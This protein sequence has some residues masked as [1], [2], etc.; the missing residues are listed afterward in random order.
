M[1]MTIKLATAVII[2]LG[3]FGLNWSY[4]AVKGY[5]LSSAAD[6]ALAIAAFDIAMITAHKAFEKIVPH[7]DVQLLF[8]EIFTILTFVTLALWAKL[9]LYLEDRMTKQ[10][11]NEKGRYYPRFPVGSFFISWSCV[12]AIFCFHVLIFI[13]GPTT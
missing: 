12:V 10:Y 7:P 4:R 5:A 8:V 2:P 13:W 1:I 11:D 6:F 9:F 3:F